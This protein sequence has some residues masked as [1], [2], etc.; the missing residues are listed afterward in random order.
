MTDQNTRRQRDKM[1]LLERQVQT[2]SQIIDAK[3]H[4]LNDANR[5]IAGNRKERDHLNDA[6]AAL[7]AELQAVNARLAGLVRE[8]R[9]THAQ[10]G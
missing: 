3:N 6:N 10:E 8:A 2:Q 7:R 5:I 4:A 1:D 9:I